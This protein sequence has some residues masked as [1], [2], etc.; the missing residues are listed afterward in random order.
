MDFTKYPL[1]KTIDSPSDLKKLSYDELDVLCA[2]IRTLLI[3]NV[4][5]SGGHLASN[6]GVVELTIA[7]H[8]VLDLPSDKIV[9]DVG[10]QCYTHK[11]LTGRRELFDTLRSAGGLSGFTKRSES[12]FDAF[13]AG[14][15]STSVSAALGL[16]IADKMQGKDNV[17]VALLGDGAFT[18]GIVHEALNNIP[19][20]LPF[21]IVLNE[22]EMSISKNT[23]AFAS[24][25]A[26][27]RNTGSYYKAKKR[28]RNFVSRIP[29]IGKPMIN[30]MISA[31]QFLKNAIYSSN[32]FEDM[33][34]FYIGPVDGHDVQR[35][36]SAMRDAISRKTG[37]IIHVK[38]TKGKGLSAAE[39]NPG[40]YHSV[41]PKSKRSDCATFSSVFG[42]VL[43]EKAKDDEK[44]CAITAAMADGCGL[45]RF[46][47]QFPDRLFDVGIAE[48]H[49]AIFAAGLAAGGM[50]PVFAVYS[51]F[52]QRAYDCVIHDVALQDLPVVFAV[53]RAGLAAADGPTHHGIYDVAFLS[54]IPGVEIWSPYDYDSLKVAFDSAMTA[55]GPVCIRYPSG[56]ANESIVNRVPIERGDIRLSFEGECDGYVITYGRI[57]TEAIHACDTLSD[58]GKKVKIILLNRLRPYDDIAD[59]VLAELA[60][61][62]APIVF[63]EE[64]I[65][66]AGASE[67]LY[68][69]MHEKS[70]F[71][72]RSVKILAVDGEFG[73]SKKG[74]KLYKTLGI[75]ADDVVNAFVRE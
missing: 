45:T 4:D 71:R 3:E 50:K 18:G 75:S 7:L 1:L 16:A 26:K 14:H 22:N 56:A 48:E 65:R 35:L 10:H 17:T 74:E 63:L 29:L 27:I 57:V 21:I 42:N 36:E 33:G 19:A 23:G 39:Q 66:T 67:N 51:T 8:R 70:D 37:V 34:L 30:A 32:Y 13:G 49:A 31:K 68:R 20:N 72:Q 15:S 60:S 47:E 11:L 12:E 52:L 46:A 43:C 54:T 73:F 64:G 62:D 53:D 55:K 9:F 5:L 28:T 41:T 59:Q 58:M 40:L 24:H 6:L 25:I 44:I 61:K 38:T 2:E 69:T